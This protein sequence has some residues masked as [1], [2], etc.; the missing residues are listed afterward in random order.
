MKKLIETVIET[1][2]DYQILKTDLEGDGQLNFKELNTL[3]IPDGIDK[4]KGVV[5]SGRQPLWLA[6]TYYRILSECPWFAV[7]YPQQN[8]AIIVNSLVQDRKVFETIPGTEILNEIE[9][10]KSS[11][12]SIKSKI[13]GLIGPP[14]SGKTVL[15]NVIRKGLISKIGNSYHNDVSILRACPDG[16]GDWSFDSDQ[17]VVK[18]IRTKNQWTDDF[19]FE[20]ASIIGKFK[21]NKKIIFVD[22]G[23]KIDKRNQIILNECTHAIIISSKPDDIPEWR[24]ACKTS[25][26]EIIA[27]INSVLEHVSV[28]IPYINTLKM[29]YGKLDRSEKDFLDLPQELINKI[30]S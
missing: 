3:K 24:G 10:N 7:F 20:M 25:N 28:I 11:E 22:C 26:I 1:E 12:E 13:I 14:H 2:Y 21:Q 6:I 15:L 9:R 27:E 8:V 17:N 29:T 16:E 18:R 4:S 23:G 30:I 5:L 19:A